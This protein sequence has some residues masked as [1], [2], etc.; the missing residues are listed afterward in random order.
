M[1]APIRGRE[2][3]GVC[4]PGPAAAVVR[5]PDSIQLPAEANTVTVAGPV[6]GTGRSTDSCPKLLLGQQ[7]SPP[8]EV[9]TDG[10]TAHPGASRPRAVARWVLPVRTSWT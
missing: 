1:R 8:Q 4:L 7:H 9:W 6:A 10:T 5:A 2:P 3:V